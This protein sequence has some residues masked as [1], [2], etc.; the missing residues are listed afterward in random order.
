[1]PWLVLADWALVGAVLMF[2]AATA[3]PR[4]CMTRV[5]VKA[6]QKAPLLI[7]R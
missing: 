7:Q 4:S 5:P 3:M 2:A 6:A 1:M